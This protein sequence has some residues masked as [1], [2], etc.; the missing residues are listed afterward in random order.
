MYDVF[1]VIYQE[2]VPQTD[3][4]HIRR[5][6]LTADCSD[7]S[8]IETATKKKKTNHSLYPESR[9]TM[10]DRCY[11]MTAHVNQSHCMLTG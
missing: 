5:L 7:W 8:S 2:S 11:G 6:D 1:Q 4:Y 9:L 3:L 10:S